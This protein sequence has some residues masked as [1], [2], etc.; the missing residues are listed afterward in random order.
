MLSLLYFYIFV[1]GASFG[2]FVNVLAYRI[3]NNLSILGRSSCANCKHKLAWFD[4]IP[5][6]SY[7]TLQGK[8]RYCASKISLIHPVF[9][10]ITGIS[11]LTFVI[12]IQFAL[13]ITNLLLLLLVLT[14]LLIA[15]TDFYY[16][17]IL[18]EYLLLVFAIGLILNSNSIDSYLW[19][20]CLGAFLFWLIYFFS[21]G[22]AMGY[23]DVKYVF[24][25]GLVLSF[26]WLFL[27][28]Y[29]AFLTGGIVSAILILMRHKNLKSTIAFGPFLSVGFLISLWLSL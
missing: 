15:L 1:L 22:R 13:S 5:V 20:A 16:Q 3:P 17:I 27:G 14:I 23:G 18:D 26:Y 19:S 24:V 4:L 25:V 11:L 8:C 28:L 29:L 21:K 9:E 7:V 2:S 12:K 10:I 6:V